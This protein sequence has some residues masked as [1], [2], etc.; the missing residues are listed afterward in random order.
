MIGPPGSES[1][2]I[3]ADPVS[4]LAPDPYPSIDKLQLAIVEVCCNC[5]CIK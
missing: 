3:F 2:I 5:T 4:D 1:V